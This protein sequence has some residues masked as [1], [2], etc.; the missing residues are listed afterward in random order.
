MNNEIDTSRPNELFLYNVAPSWNVELVALLIGKDLVEREEDVTQADQ[1]YLE[2]R[3]CRSTASKERDNSDN[4]DSDTVIIRI[5]LVSEHQCNVLRRSY[6]GMA[7]PLT[8]G[9]HYYSLSKEWPPPDELTLNNNDLYQENDKIYHQTLSPP[10]HLQLMALSTCQLKQKW[11][12]Y[13]TQQQNTED[14]QNALD[15]LPTPPSHSSKVNRVWQHAALAYT[16]TRTL[17]TMPPQTQ[18]IDGVPLDDSLT[19]PLLQALRT[20]T[21]WPPRDQQRTGIQAGRYLTLRRPRAHHQSSDEHTTL[22]NLCRAVWDSVVGRGNNGN[23]DHDYTALAITHNVQGSPHTDRHDTT[24]QHVVALGDFTGGHLCVHQVD[25]GVDDGRDT[26]TIYR[27]TRINVHN[28]LARLD[29][30]HVHWVDAWQGTERYSVVFYSTSSV[31][32]TKPAPQSVHNAWMRRQQSKC[33][34]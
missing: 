8:H 27:I 19:Q 9:Y 7:V 33:H 20:C 3:M 6:H 1:V 29:G 30:R 13:N 2:R 28:R 16:V 25:D 32:A 17:R 26:N 15:T 10:F 21:L 14:D 31:H 18:D 4:H 34:G 24:F 11:K 23:Y 22:W 5:I 12:R